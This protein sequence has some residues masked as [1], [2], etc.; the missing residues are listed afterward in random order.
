[1]KPQNKKNESAGNNPDYLAAG[2]LVP[3]FSIS[4]YRPLLKYKFL[5]LIPF[6]LLILLVS[7]FSEPEKEQN[8]NRN[9]LFNDGWKF[10]RD[11]IA[12][13]EKPNFDDSKWMSVDLPHDFSIMNLSGGDSDDQIGPFSKKSPGM[14][15]TGYTMGGTGWY[16]KT[17]VLGEE[18]KDKK[19]S[20]KFDGVYMETDVWVNGQKVGTHKNGYTPFWYDITPFL[21]TPGKTNTLAV[22]AE[23]NGKNSRWYSGSGIYRNV[24]L[25]I[26][27][28]VHIAEWGA[29]ITTPIVSADN[30]EVNVQITAQNDA[31]TDIKAQLQINLKNKEGKV[32]ATETDEITIKAFS[33]NFISNK[34]VVGHPDL[35]SIDS[36]NIYNAE[37]ILKVG[38]KVLDIYKQKFGIRSIQFSA[39]KGFLLNG[40]SVLLKGACLHHDNGFLGA[41][42]F[43]R[44]EYRRVELMK[45]NGFNAIRCSHNPPSEAFLNACD[46]I[47]VLVIDEFTDMWQHYKNPQDY[48]RFFN[49]WW[50]KD[51]TD[52]M[53]RDR[54]HPSIIIWS[55]GNEIPK[56]GFEEGAQTGKM[57]ATKVKELDNT[58]PVTEAI[59]SFLVHG[60]WDNSQHYFNFLDVCGYNYL[61][62][63]Y[64]PDHVKYPNRVIFSSESY[65][66]QA[67]DYWKGVQDL[68]YVIGD[69]VWAGMDYIGEVS[70]GNSNYS[71]E[72]KPY[73]VQTTKG[74][75]IG[76]PASAVFDYMAKMDKSRWPAFVSWCGDIDII[77]EKK[78]QGLYRDVLWGNS[79]I[80]INVHE[81]IPQGLVENLS[82]WGW[83]NELPTWNWGVNNNELL[84]VRV[85]TQAPEVKLELN[86]KI[87]GEKSLKETDKYIAEFKVPYQPGKLTAIALNNGKEIARKELVTTGIP[88]AVKL[89]ADRQKIKADRNDLSFVKIEV[90]DK[91]GQVVTY[92]SA[93]LE[94]S[95]TGNGEL[96]ASGNSNPED[97]KSVNRTSLNTFRGKAQAII[98]PYKDKGKITLSVSSAGLVPSEITIEVK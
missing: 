71:N 81:P 90:V 73:S 54:N 20:L 39:D 86:G 76:T 29:Y 52:M 64:V 70:V 61:R 24:N 85:F 1:M 57:I 46:E 33:N 89:T 94:I 72:E 84:Q 5:V 13:A 34:M 12:G 28:R 93:Q 44:A 8:L 21:N 95:L 30:A 79:I 35:W 53:K 25:V 23:S 55:I 41:A 7:G 50:E 48:S 9:R 68:S 66:A 80:E 4:K 45:A 49:E 26:T 17:F 92:E 97:M 60:D 10:I 27:N 43:E 96:V 38:N 87:I 14:N 56:S 22:R 62:Q 88:V 65:P 59:T 32:C 40:K 37:I 18:D 36:P 75:P 98:R 82:L 47:G 2:H 16:R 58:R 69:F 74:I 83:P 67:Y 91:N 42:A 19:V 3:S 6:I 15:N 11:S 77:G 31:D 63:E 78:P 51:L